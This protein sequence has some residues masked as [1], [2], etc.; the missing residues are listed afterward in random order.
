MRSLV[1]LV[2]L[3]GCFDP[4]FTEP[5]CGPDD[6]C[7][8]G[9]RCL[10][11]RCLPSTCTAMLEAMACSTP[12]APDGLCLRDVC[13]PRGCGDGILTSDEVCDPGL[14][15]GPCSADCRSDLTCGN[16]VAD[17]G[18]QCDPDAVAGL[19][20]DG[21]TST[22]EV[23]F[24]TWRDVTPR[25]LG[26]LDFIHEMVEDPERDTVWLVGGVD[27]AETTLDIWQ[28][29]GSNWVLR[30]PVSGPNPR[31][32]P[33][34][35]IAFDRE[36]DR[37]VMFGDRTGGIEVPGD[38]WEWDPETLA[39]SE[40]STTAPTTGLAHLAIAYDRMRHETILVGRKNDGSPRTE[41]WRWDGATWTQASD[42]AALYSDGALLADLPDGGVLLVARDTR[43]DADPAN[44]RMVTYRW[45]GTGWDGGLTPSLPVRE[46]IAVAT[47][48]MQV[49]AYGGLTSAQQPSPTVYAWNA[50]AE[51]W[52][53][54]TIA[55][56]PRAH[57]G[58][59]MAGFG[60]LLLVQGGIADLE[61][62][63]SSSFVLDGDTWRGLDLLPIEFRNAAM[64]YDA[65]RGVVVLVMETVSASSHVRVHE[66]NGRQW[67]YRPTALGPAPRD[68]M[69]LAFD[70]RRI[71]MFG[72]C[73]TTGATPYGETWTWDGVAWT[74]ESPALAPAARWASAMVGTPTGAILVGG[75]ANAANSEAIGDAWQ[76]SAETRQWTRLAT[77][78][79][80]RLG[81]AMAYDAERGL[82]LLFGGERGTSNGRD[83]LDETWAWDGDAWQDITGSG[84]DA[85]PPARAFATMTY[86]PDRGAIVLV[87]GQRPEGVGFANLGDTWELAGA[88][89]RESAL[90]TTPPRFS[91]GSSAYDGQTHRMLVGYSDSLTQHTDAHEYFTTSRAVE[92]CASSTTDA[93]GDGLAGCADPDCWPRCDPL[94]SPREPG[95]CAR[96]RCGDGACNEALEDA[97]LCPVDCP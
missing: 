67:L 28:F 34:P 27:R 85:A 11:D 25:A 61:G 68:G 74:Q 55:G 97:S 78:P 69:A 8:S 3:V 47:V 66:W 15:N 57:Y 39:W 33:E 17:A 71:V 82:V 92:T 96:S 6:A 81:H 73:C 54:R 31:S 36:R 48:E 19:S 49:L 26:L 46:G 24:E 22:C 13:V 23:E 88:V 86:D 65:L 21:C 94:C 63:T 40:H 42:V 87:G 77:A 75:S 9:M 7:P 20:H 32:R 90:P 51:A 62:S 30:T 12:S 70:G 18:E 4:S 53:A 60:A 89:W 14:T 79:S 41:T 5:R 56:T 91:S 44:D 64:A 84:V 1:A 35:L 52:Q 37:L 93:D 16:A 29:D 10:G 83:V 2:A 58:H 76:W 59:A 50:A 72:G 95:A 45:T 43:D 80:P 38:T